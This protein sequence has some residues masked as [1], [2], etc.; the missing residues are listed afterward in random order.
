[1]I[2]YKNFIYLDVYKTGSSHVVDLLKKIVPEEPV[3]MKRHSS[4]TNLRPLTWTGGKL[5][6]STVR[7]PWDWYVSLWA[8]GCAKK[9]AVY[10]NIAD[11]LSRAE[12]AALYNPEDP[13]ASFRLWTEAVCDPDFLN[14]TIQQDLPDS[15]MARIVGFYTYRFMRVTTPFPSFLLKKWNIGSVDAAIRYQR[16]WAF[17]SVMLRNETL[18]DDLIA[19]I[20]QHRERCGFVEN[21]EQIVL[22]KAEKPKNRSKRAFDTYQDYY[23][24]DL[25]DLV[26]RRERF[27]L[28][29]FNY[30]F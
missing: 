1:M 16:K 2:E 20:R 23:D 21:A 5:V 22:E 4:L 9:G 25:V 27:F 24:P 29:L 12:T 26:A 7:N 28:E 11:T 3:R 14:R 13:K 30:A 8:Y 19:F 6:F 10:Q 15:G 18:N 17:Y